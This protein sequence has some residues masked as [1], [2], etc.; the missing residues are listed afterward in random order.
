MKD[1]QVILDYLDALL[2]TGTTFVLRRHQ[3]VS[4][5]SGTGVVADGFRFPD[6]RVVTRW[7]DTAGVQQTCVWDS[8]VHVKKIH[9]H[10]GATTIDAVP[11]QELIG[12]I[13]NNIVGCGCSCCEDIAAD[14]ID[15]IQREAEMDAIAKGCTA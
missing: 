1:R 6:G 7:R 14:L 4:G 9:G 15:L 3:D 12:I 8:L 11:I 2:P 13:R 10:N 5:V